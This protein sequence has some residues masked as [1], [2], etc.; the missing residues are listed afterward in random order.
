MVRF[1]P[2]A[3]IV[4]LAVTM[5]VRT[6]A[7][8]VVLG[9]HA[10]DYYSPGAATS[11][12]PWTENID[13]GGYNLTDVGALTCD[14]IA[15]AAGDLQLA[16]ALNANSNAIYGVSVFT[17][18]AAA[19]IYT[20][21]LADVSS[22]GIVVADDF[23]LQ[24]GASIYTDSLASTSDTS[25]TIVDAPQLVDPGGTVPTCSE[26]YDGLLWYEDAAGGDS[27]YVCHYDGAAFTN[28][29]LLAAAGFDGDLATDTALQDSSDNEIDIAASQTFKFNVGT[30]LNCNQTDGDCRIQEAAGGTVSGN[31][32]IL[33]GGSTAVSVRESVVGGA[34]I[35][36]YKADGSTFTDVHAQ[37]YQLRETGTYA[38]TA[39]MGQASSNGYILLD[40][41]GYIGYGT[42][43][44]APGSG[45][46]LC[47]DGSGDILWPERTSA[48]SS[49]YDSA[50]AAAFAVG[51]SNRTRPACSDANQGRIELDSEDTGAHAVICTREYDGSATTYAWDTLG[52]GALGSI[53]MSTGSGA[54]DVNS[55]AK[56]DDGTSVYTEDEALNFDVNA[57]GEM[58]A[59]DDGPTRYKI[60]WSVTAE[61]SASGA[62]NEID[63]T[64]AHDDN[65]ASPT[66]T[67]LAACKEHI[68][69]PNG[70]QDSRTVAGNCTTT[71]VGAI[72]V[73]G[74]NNDEFYLV[75]QNS[76]GTNDVI[77]DHAS[78][79]IEAY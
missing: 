32:I 40:R 23:T 66:V 10:G 22:G 56:L 59:V 62:A 33:G 79:L 65:E 53:Y 36:M 42:S 20:D 70:D 9:S 18:D 60:W 45:V 15:G 46:V 38:S 74:T 19:S 21:N 13:G 51:Y 16:G 69:W 8:P 37:S 34:D 73:D 35:D 17:M 25:F 2:Y 30:I 71:E 68:Y 57:T 28:K 12:T 76:S 55:W 26:T 1:A 39:Q 4:A 72:D 64:V 52:A 49:A 7:Q 41:E 43:S 29:D 5:G 11:L 14:S 44:T 27:L 6:Y 58:I 47:G 48:C 75:G 24:A 67:P 50:D 61:L 78:I 31:G 63:F 54:I 3:V 77:I